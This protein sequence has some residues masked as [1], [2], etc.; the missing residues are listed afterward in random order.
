MRAYLSGTQNVRSRF[1]RTPENPQICRGT[2]H[3]ITSLDLAVLRCGA[4]QSGM[5]SCVTYSDLYVSARW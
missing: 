1:R 3:A 4:L 5:L 2:P